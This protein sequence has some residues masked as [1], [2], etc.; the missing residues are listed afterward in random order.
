M[1]I[2]TEITPNPDS[3]KFMTGK[4]IMRYGTADFSNE[5][6]T[7]DAP[8]AKKLFNFTFVDRVFFGNTFITITRKKD[9]QWE[10]VI[11][12]VKS[13]LK[14]YFASNQ[15]VVTGKYL[16]EIEEEEN[17]TEV[18]KKIKEIINNSVRPAIAMDGGD[19][20]FERFEDGIVHL[21]LQGSC[22]GCPSSVFTLKRGVEGLLTRMIPEVKSVEAVN[23]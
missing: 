23:G 14:S 22:S 20:I 2:Y 1:M 17:D 15:E 3:L 19:I 18:V 16:E 9:F 4:L 21:R 11:P 7:E 10:E 5:D 8:L 6:Q 12:V 13:F